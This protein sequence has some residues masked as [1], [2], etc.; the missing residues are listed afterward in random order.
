MW[1]HRSANSP[2]ANNLA[3]T[4]QKQDQFVYQIQWTEDM[5]VGLPRID[6][7]HKQLISISNILIAATAQGEGKEALVDVYE[8]LKEYTQFHFKDEEAYME[9]LGYPDLE[10]HKA[11]HALLYMRVQT[12]R[13]MID[14]DKTITPEGT[15]LFLSNWI[16]EHL[17]GSDTRIGIF[18]KQT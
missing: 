11:E 3:L 12:L 1:M 10:K 8:R 13:R 16:C 4:A 7:Q 2:V 17:I 18:A 6:D 15:S 14:N 5:T 9:E